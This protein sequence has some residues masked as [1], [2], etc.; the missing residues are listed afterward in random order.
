MEDE[1][2]EPH[3][4]ATPAE[5]STAEQG[6]GQS[7][8]G[9]EAAAAEDEARRK[10]E[11][12]AEEAAVRKKP[13]FQ[14]RID[15][16]TRQRHE[17]E[18]RAERLERLLEQLIQRNQ[19]ASP[20]TPPGPPGTAP[21]GAPPVQDFPPTR[22][23]P[24]RE[25]YDFD[26]ERYLQAMVDWRLEQREAAERRRREADEQQRA[27]QQFQAEFATRA[28]RIMA[29]G[30]ERYPD[31]EAAVSAV[32]GDIFDLPTALAISETEYPVEIAYHLAKNLDE[33]KRIASLPP[34]KK[35]VELGKLEARIAN[36]A[37]KTTQA[38]PPPK[39]LGGKEPGVV[40]ESEL[41]MEEWLK[42]RAAG[43]ITGT[44]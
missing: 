7:D 1:A 42:L 10:A 31:F 37:K 28:Q 11:E 41:P 20:Q 33:A 22:P 39:T 32:P 2:K 17:A 19:A 25:Q 23:A 21:Q 13:W 24:T 43:K 18:R 44:S 30:R 34:I 4:D 40:R 8:T 35:A 16:I 14:R 9:A 5:S 12:E 15:E 38:P 26:E 3:Q 6:V 36:A 27:A 29:E